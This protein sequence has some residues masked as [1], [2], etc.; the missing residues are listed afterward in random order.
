MR[1]LHIVHVAELFCIYSLLGKNSRLTA[2]VEV[3][4]HFV[5]RRVF[6]S[7]SAS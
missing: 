5:K 2:A 6:W 4:L 7:Y 3:H 1:E